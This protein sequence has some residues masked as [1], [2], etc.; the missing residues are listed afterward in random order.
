[1]GERLDS[2]KEIAKYLGR[3]V[4]TVQRWAVS[5]RL[6]VHHLPGGGRPRVFSLK[7]EIDAWL[8]AGLQKPA[9]ETPSVAVLPFLNL[10]AS[11]GNS[12]FGD[13]LAEELINAL[14]RIPGLRV[15]AR[16]S[17]FAF[18][19]R[20]HD[21]REIGTQLGTEWLL[22]GSVRR[23]R[24][25]VRVA[26]QLINTRDGC[27]AWSECY[28]RRLTDIFDIQEELARSIASALKV[29]LSAPVSSERPTE[30]LTAYDLW[31]KG[32]SISQQFTLEA[33]TQARECFESA[34]ARDPCFARPYFGLA[35]L[36]FYGVQFGL[37]PQPDDL[38][39]IRTAIARSLQ[40]DD[41]NGE[42]HAL[43]GVCL[44]LL[45]HD[46]AA[47]ESSFQ[48]AMALI[49]GSSLVLSEHAWYHLVP[50]MRLTE[51]LDHAQ[52]AVALDPLSPLA[53]GV[54]GLVWVAARKY[55]RAV[56]E[57]RKAVELAPTLW[58]LRWFYGT[59]LLM[60]A[61]FIQGY[62]EF[63]VAYAKIHQPLIVGAMALVY[64]LSL[65]RKKAKALLSELQKMSK[66]EYVPPA[67]YALAYLGIGD[68]RVFEWL[69]KAIDARDPI[70]THLPSMPMYDGIRDDPR[71]QALLVR[72][73]LG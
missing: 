25:R 69:E 45:D 8:K 72:M 71:F 31:V 55:P 48:R 56:E 60:N 21:V 7:T 33:F 41:R 30:D 50:R 58:W 14:V 44:G 20:G 68:D 1:V 47:A 46:W 35:E 42:A 18:S 61:R 64:G 40:L 4:R 15:I 22:E 32:R 65:R 43:Q 59:A 52:Q 9:G 62:R 17:S 28:E 3:E 6:P 34:L 29:K 70:V 27:H 11:E 51:A 37:T 2:W 13:G 57:C 73:H 39:R 24:R 12:Y 26:A 19:K 16:T 10:S 66:T 63:Q 67:A 23:D 36:L 53:R 54:L 5:R 38:P 49:P